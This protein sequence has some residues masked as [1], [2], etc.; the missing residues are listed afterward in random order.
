MI[1]KVI[2]MTYKMARRIAIGVVGTS[3]LLIGLL[4]IFTPG[5]ALLVIP[6]GLAILSVEFAW[7][8]MWLRRVRESISEQASNSRVARAVRARERVDP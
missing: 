3:V 1:R 8:R 5:P 4:M 2:H 6:V 7:A